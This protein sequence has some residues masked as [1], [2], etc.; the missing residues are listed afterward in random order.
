MEI[1]ALFIEENF[2]F[3]NVWKTGVTLK[4]LRKDGFENEDSNI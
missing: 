3:D 2:W 4:T 1:R